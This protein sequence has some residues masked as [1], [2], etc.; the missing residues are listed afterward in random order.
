M[1]NFF[2]IVFTYH[3]T[4]E[5]PLISKQTQERFFIV[6]DQIIEICCNKSQR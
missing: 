1:C 5:V 4:D 3:F 2:V 6:F